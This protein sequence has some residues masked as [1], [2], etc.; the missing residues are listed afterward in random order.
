MNNLKYPDVEVDIVGRDGNAFNILAIC[1]RALL[2]AGYGTEEWKEFEAEATAGD[3]GNLLVTVMTYF[4][5]AV[6]DD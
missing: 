5:I 6:M 2:D 4:K 3:Y 1:R